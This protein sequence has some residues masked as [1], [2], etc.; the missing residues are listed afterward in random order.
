MLVTGALVAVPAGSS[1]HHGVAPGDCAR[2]ETGYRCIY[3]PF[4]I[5][6]G[7]NEFDDLV[8]AP[9]EAGFITRAQATVL[10]EEK[11]RMKGHMVHL[12]HAVWANPSRNDMTCSDYPLDRFFASGKERT[13][14]ELPAGYGYYWDNQPP[15][16]GFPVPHDPERPVWALQAHIDGMHEG[17]AMEVYLAFDLQFT[18]GAPG[19]MTDVTPAWFDIDNCGDSEFKVPRHRNEEGRFRYKTSWNYTME[20]AG[21]FVAMAGHLH[22]GGVKLSLKNLTA[23]KPVFTSRASY[24]SVRDP[25]YLT[26][27]SYLSADPGLPVEAGDTLKL[28]AVYKSRQAIEDAMGI[29]VGAFVPE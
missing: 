29:M 8:A 4:P 23:G 12:H 3:G 2:T 22:D 28:T 16:S 18:P 5:E 1:A 15:R 11:Q 7:M 27:M 21:R 26:S 19:D 10:N 24:D 6:Y 9:P 17:H 14:L 20:D 25:N 13:P